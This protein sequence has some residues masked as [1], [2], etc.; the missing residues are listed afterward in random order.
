MAKKPI[1]KYPKNP[2]AKWP[3]TGGTLFEATPFDSWWTAADACNRDNVWDVI[4]FNFQTTDGAEVNYYMANLLGCTKLSKNKRDYSF[5]RKDGLPIYIYLPPSNWKLDPSAGAPP[6]PQRPAM[7]FG[8][9]ATAQIV[10]SVLGSAPMG[11][12]NFQV[13]S[14]HINTLEFRKVADR[15]RS[16]TI[17]VYQLPGDSEVARYD[18]EANALHVRFGWHLTEQAKIVHE[19]VHA[20]FDLKKACNIFTL[21]DEAAAYLAESIYAQV[22]VHPS[23]RRQLIGSDGET[24]AIFLAAYQMAMMVLRGV[25]IVDADFEALRTAIAAHSEYKA[26]AR[27][28]AGYDGIYEMG[29]VK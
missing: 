17:S 25:E 26:G 23:D 4:Y 2:L 16:G 18:P 22:S 1:V 9:A 11:W 29:P 6:K 24:E 28:V 5:G 15:I 20:I 8:D 3:P 10:L 19:T 12:M 27:D 14:Y 13:G 7:D 21:D